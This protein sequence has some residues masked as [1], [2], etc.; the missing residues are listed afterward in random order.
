M[1]E[2]GST[3]EHLARKKYDP[4]EVEMAGWILAIGSAIDLNSS[5]PTQV[6]ARRGVKTI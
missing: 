2:A 3:E 5:V 4:G 1:W 6:D